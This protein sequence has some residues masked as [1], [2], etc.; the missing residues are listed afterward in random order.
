MPA[1]PAGAKPGKL[2][3]APSAEAPMDQIQLTVTIAVGVTLA[4]LLLFRRRD[5][6]RLPD[7]E[8]ETGGLYSTNNGDGR[9]GVVKLLAQDPSVVHLR[10]YKNTYSTR[11][12]TIEPTDLALGSMDDEDGFGIGH[13]PLARG[14]FLDWQPALLARQDVSEEELEG[15]RLW[16]QAD[17]GAF[18][19]PPRGS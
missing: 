16:Q 3:E 2:P 19:T 7:Q 12:A 18:G 4:A 10:L 9:Y 11:P 14:D 13:L 15:Y 6:P 8:L 1:L 17:G 5:R